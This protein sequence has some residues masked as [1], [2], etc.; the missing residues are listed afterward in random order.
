MRVNG[1]S[2]QHLDQLGDEF[3]ALVDRGIEQAARV[4]TKDLKATWTGDDLVVIQRVFDRYALDTLVPELAKHYEQGIQDQADR[5]TQ[6]ALSVTAAIVL[7]SPPATLAEQYLITATNRLKGISDEVWQHTRTELVAGMQAGESVPQLRKRVMAAADVSKARANVIARTEV[8]GAQNRGSLGQMMSTGYGGTKDW[9]ATR[10]HRTRQSHADANG[11]TVRL[12][13]KFSVGG[14]SMDGPHD[15]SAPPGETISCRCTLTY[16][17]D[18]TKIVDDAVPDTASALTSDQYAALTPGR[19]KVTGNKPIPRD[20]SSILETTRQGRNTLESIKR[21]TQ[22]RGGVAK[23]RT[24]VAE[25]LSGQASEHVA[26]RTGDF[27]A[28]MNNYPADQVPQLYR[29]IGVKPDPAQ[30]INAW[31]DAFEAQYKV[32]ST[33]DLTASSFTSSSAKAESFMRAPGGSS[34]G[35]AGLVQMKVIVDGQLS[36]LPVQKLSKFA[37]EKEWISGGRFVVTQMLPPAPPKRLYYEV[38]IR[39]TKQLGRP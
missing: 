4:A 26:E 32:G 14:A 5:V 23:L 31:F 9:L 16:E 28:A 18:D 22:T 39:Q 37:A 21:F 15:P 11:Q 17:I 25:T 3:A 30:N 20:P 13:E 19:P 34:T 1:P 7:P 27:L 35:K 8:I 2:R 6:A 12:D 33:I 36:A 10:D 24:D 38:H 29:G